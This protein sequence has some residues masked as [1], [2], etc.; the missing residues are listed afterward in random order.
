V[1]DYNRI[2]GNYYCG[3]V[4]IQDSMGVSIITDR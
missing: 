4:E 2:V 1:G 3:V